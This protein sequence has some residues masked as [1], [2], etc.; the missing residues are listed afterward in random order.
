ME[1]YQKLHKLSKHTRTLQGIS[2]ILGWDQETYMPPGAGENRGEQLKI[3]AGLIHREKTSPEYIATLGELVDLKTG[4]VKANGLEENKQAALREWYRDYKRDNALSS[5]FVED[6]AQLN[7]QSLLVWR[8]AKEKNAFHHFAPFLDR[9]IDMCRKKADLL[10]YKEHPYDALLDLYEHDISTE[11]VYT[12]FSN[13]K[14]SL[15]PLLKKI[16]R[17]KQVDDSFLHGSFPAKK[18]MAFTLKLLKDIGYDMSHGRLDFS[19]HPF[20]TASHPTDSRITTHIHPK[21]I[22]SNIAIVLH[23]AGHSL[24]EMGLPREEFGTPLGESISLGMHES[25]SRFWETRVGHSK[26]FWQHYL[27]LLKKQFKGK[28]DNISLEAFY[29]GINKVNASY[30]RVE[31]DEVTYSLHVILRFEMEKALI[32]GSLKVRDI[33]DA[34]NAKMQELL[35]V[36]P[37]NNTEGCLQDVHWA[38]GAFGYFPSYTLGNLYASHFFEA[39]ANQHKDWNQRIAEGQFT[40]IVDW[41]RENIH[42]HGRRY[43]STKLLQKITGKPFTAETFIHYITSKYSDIYQT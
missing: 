34:W 35:G 9:T 38:M 31:A 21:H 12:L 2:N 25:Q 16:Q 18:Q 22:L 24:Y 26:P 43:S 8:H 17:Q 5:A 3:M 29:K 41:L 42:K 11:E 6:F 23:E 20:S 10:G 39:F 32:E 27:P 37:R 1:A 28:L 19:A 30:I 4:N 15:L 40:F 36:T 7:S 14:A 13:L 33:P